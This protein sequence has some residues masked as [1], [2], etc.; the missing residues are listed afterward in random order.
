[1]TESASTA[2]TRIVQVSLRLTV[3]LGPAENYSDPDSIEAQVKE[4]IDADAATFFCEQVIGTDMR[5][6]VWLY[7]K[8][9]SEGRSS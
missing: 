2:T 6:A 4:D 5:G 9:G 7:D 3:E 1:M 8:N